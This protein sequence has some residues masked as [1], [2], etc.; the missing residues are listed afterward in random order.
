MATDVAIIMMAYPAI[1]SLSIPVIQTV[2]Q[3]AVIQIVLRTMMTIAR[4]AGRSGNCLCRLSSWC[5]SKR[6]SSLS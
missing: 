5:S 4:S 3:I 2:R 1:A 6:L